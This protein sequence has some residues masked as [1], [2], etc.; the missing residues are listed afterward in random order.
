MKHGI[1]HKGAV[2]INSLQVYF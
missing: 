1:T 2:E